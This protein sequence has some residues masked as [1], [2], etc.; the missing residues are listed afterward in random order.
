MFILNSMYRRHK[1][2]IPQG[3][4]PVGSLGPKLKFGYV[5]FCIELLKKRKFTEIVRTKFCFTSVCVL[6]KKLRDIWSLLYV[7]NDALSRLS[8]SAAEYLQEAAKIFF[9]ENKTVC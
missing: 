5:R 6:S 8:V 3:A 1:A 2:W 7:A 9:R 4:G